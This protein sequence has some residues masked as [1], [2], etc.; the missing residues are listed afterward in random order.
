MDA[1]ETAGYSCPSWLTYNQPQELGGQVRKGE[2]SSRVV[3]ANTFTKKEQAETGEESEQ[4]IPFLKEY[5][6]FNAEQCDGLPAEFTALELLVHSTP[7]ERLDVA[8]HF[9]RNT[10]A[11]IENG[12]TRLAKRDQPRRD[13]NA[14]PA[15]VPDAKATTRQHCTS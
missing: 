8:D 12:G 6:V 4:K 3:Y 15:D 10:G 2:R 7:P 9:V 5:C 11:T 14:G 13:Q 1:A